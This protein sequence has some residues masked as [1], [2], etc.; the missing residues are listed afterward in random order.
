[1]RVL[2]VGGG[3][4]GLCVAE[5]LSARAAEVTVLEAGVIGAGASA[6][7]AGW[8]TP[9]LAIPVPAPGVVSAALR[10]LA[11]ASSP[12]WIRPT[13]EP[14]LLAWVARFLLSC[15]RSPYTRGLQALQLLAGEAG[16][17]FDRLGERGAQF[18]R[19]DEPLLYPAFDAEELAA[20]R[21]TAADVAA[22]GA[23]PA[24]HDLTGDELRALEPALSPEVIG[25]TVAAGE[26]R[27]RPETFTLALRR[28]LEERRVAVQEHARVQALVRVPG[29]WMAHTPAGAH[30]ATAVILAN[31][32]GVRRL[33]RPLGA[34][35]PVLT[36]KGFSRTFPRAAAGA[37]RRAMYLEAPRVAI[38]VFDQAV[39][40]SGGLGLG[41]RR[42]DLSPRR[43]AAI[44]AAAGRA[45]PTWRMPPQSDDWAGLRTLSP[46][47]LPY[48]GPL[49]G[50][51]GL[52]VAT[53]HATLG[54]TLAPLSGVLLADLLL[55]G[56][57]APARRAADPGRALRRQAARSP[58]A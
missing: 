10:W 30:R 45:L 16:G 55:D 35:L 42:L 21:H 33:L 50:L 17:A 26:A 44:T 52:H 25:G 24:I 18:E 8:I 41:A 15:R 36:G 27:V 48:L 11:S 22:A 6:G 38:S 49:P 12:L 1:M 29:G 51:D 13:L 57:D 23:S 20:L 40:I 14:V 31:G 34:A 28:L 5:A 4:V 53:A 46:D 56:Q 2:V 58:S 32:A 47:G 19:H 39:R 9:S 7:N 37:P 43:L 3:A 54:I